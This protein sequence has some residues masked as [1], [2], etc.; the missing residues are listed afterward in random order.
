MTLEENTAQGNTYTARK[1]TSYTCPG[2]G[3]RSGGFACRDPA[4]SPAAATLFSGEC[5]SDVGAL[6]RL[7]PARL[8]SARLN[9]AV[10]QFGGLGADVEQD[11]KPNRFVL[12]H[13][14]S[15]HLDQTSSSG[16]VSLEW[17]HLTD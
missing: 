16:T 9:P 7:G 17:K 12:V 5:L 2:L 8:G 15:P 4:G 14:Q 10:K 6:I 11:H 13:I 3:V 1:K